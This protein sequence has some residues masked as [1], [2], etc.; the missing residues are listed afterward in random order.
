M[1]ARPGKFTGNTPDALLADPY[2]ALSSPAF[3]TYCLLWT[4]RTIAWGTQANP[5]PATLKECSRIACCHTLYSTLA[6]GGDTLKHGRAAQKTVAICAAANANFLQETSIVSEVYADGD[7]T[8]LG[9]RNDE[10]FM[11]YNML[12]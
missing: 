1:L 3:L 4:R 12:E 9:R 6:L 7:N 11:V 2:C 10:G 5:R 8:V